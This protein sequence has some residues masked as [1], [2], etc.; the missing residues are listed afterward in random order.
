LRQQ[1]VLMPDKPFFTYLA[2]WCYALAATRAQGVTDRYTGQADDGRDALRD[3]TIARQKQL[4]TS[5]VRHRRV[6]ENDAE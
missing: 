1:K 6:S 4:H 3:R 5:I 2:P